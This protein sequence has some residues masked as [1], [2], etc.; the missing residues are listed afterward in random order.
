MKQTASAERS[1]DD[2][3]MLPAALRGERVAAG[4]PPRTMRDW[5]ID[6]FAFM[7]SLVW[8]F[9]SMGW[10][11]VPDLPAS[12]LEGDP[13]WLVGLDLATGLVFSAALWWRRRWPVQLALLG[14]LVAAYFVTPAVAMMILTF[15]V[16]VH[17]PFATAL[18]P[19]IAAWVGNA[20]FYALRG[21]EPGSTFLESVGWGTAILIIAVLWGATVR[22]RRQ[23]VFSLRERAERAEAEQQMRVERAKALERNRIA[24]EMHDVLAHR[25]AQLSIY[26]GGLEMSRDKVVTPRVAESAAIIRKC[27][28]ETMADLRYVIGVLREPGDGSLGDRPQP[29]LGDLSALLEESRSAGARVSFESVVEQPGTVP[30][31]TGRTIYRIVQEGL[32]NARKHAPGAVV[33]VRVEGAQGRGLSV[34]VRNPL[35]VAPPAKPPPGT[36]TGLIGLAERAELAGGT[37]THSKSPGGE[38]VLEAWL[39]WSADTAAV[40]ALEVPA[41]AEGTHL[42]GGGRA[43]AAGPGVSGENGGDQGTAGNAAGLLGARQGGA[44]GAR[45]SGA[46]GARKDRAGDTARARA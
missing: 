36:G 45:E 18:W 1:Q 24:R 30:T 25:I 17:R 21:P 5:I 23:L 4:A 31:G 41:A 3:W 43:S 19:V 38:F 32:T 13:S 35:P 29:T 2:S 10:L 37:L 26:A 34:E 11:L 39:P 40:P 12:Q 33:R 27:A 8:V 16:A 6:S 7:L 20:V 14:V 28:H 22:A 46:T 15:T 44:I 42:P 9:S